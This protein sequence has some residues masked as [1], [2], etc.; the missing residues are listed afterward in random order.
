MRFFRNTLLIAALG[1]TPFIALAAFKD[2]PTSHMHSNAILYVQLEGIVDGYDD[3]TFKPDANINRAEFTKI[4]ME[5]IGKTSVEKNC[6]SDVQEEWFAAYVCGA[7][8]AGLIDGYPDRTFKPEQN[9]S[10]VEA[11]KI[12][13]NAFE[14]ETP[15]MEGE[16]Y[17]SYVWSLQDLA[18]IPTDID[19]FSSLITRGQMAEMIYRIHSG[20]KDLPSRTFDDL[21]GVSSHSS[22]RS[23]AK[24]LASS[25][26][27]AGMNEFPFRFPVTEMW[28]QELGLRKLEEYEIGL[29]NVQVMNDDSRIKTFFR[30]LIPKGSAGVLVAEPYG[31]PLAGFYGMVG[32]KI[33][34]QSELYLRYFFRIPKDFDFGKKGSLPG[35]I[36]GMQTDTVD[37]L[38]SDVGI[39]WREEGKI[40]IEGTFS[41][42]ESNAM[43]RNIEDVLPADGEW[44][45]ID[46]YVR[47]NSEPARPNGGLKISLDDTVIAFSDGVFFQSRKGEAWDGLTF[48]ATYGSDLSSLAKKDMHI[49]VGGISLSTTGVY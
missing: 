14:K 20:N 13:V 45:Y 4:V 10:F 26:V 22:S 19:T 40:V 33:T 46:I 41:I 17:A 6:F 43:G 21:R 35:L 42:G 47:L 9:I 37:K 5:A 49:D 2:V 24:S 38:V 1:S 29:Q 32:P 11:A 36:T 18:A 30:F 7:K 48:G 3:N 15:E 27:T 23:S 8:E 28:Q 39:G 12:I 34:P 44:H 25:S 31:K 16:W